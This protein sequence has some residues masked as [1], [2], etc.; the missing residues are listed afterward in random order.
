MRRR[1]EDV[2][3]DSRYRILPPPLPHRSRPALNHGRRYP[4]RRVR[5]APLPFDAFGVLRVRQARPAAIKLVVPSR[6]EPP[7]TDRT[8][9]FYAVP[10]LV[11]FPFAQNRPAALNCNVPAFG[12]A[13]EPIQPPAEFIS[14]LNARQQVAGEISTCFKLARAMPTEATVP[15]AEFRVLRPADNRLS[16]APAVSLF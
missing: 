9:A 8:V 11:G 12:V 5:P 14:A 10:R 7:A 6:Q 3:S 13:V 2:S 1:S 15:R 4:R 16:A